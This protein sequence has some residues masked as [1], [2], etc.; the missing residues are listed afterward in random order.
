MIMKRGNYAQHAAI[1]GLGG[2]DRSGEIK[3]YAILTK[4]YGNKALSLMCA[5]GEIAYGMTKNGLRVTAVDIEPEMIAAA[6]KDDPVNTNPCFLTG[7]VTALHLPDKDYDFAFIG[8]GDFHHLLSEK[9]MLEAL[10]C[11]HRH[12]TDKG[13][14]AFELIYPGSESRQS[15]KRRFDPPNQSETSLK[16]WKLGESSYNAATMREY[17]KQEVFIEEQGRIESFSHEFELQLI[18]RETLAGL[19]EKAGFEITAEYGGY[20]FE[21]WHPGADKWL[22]EC[23]KIKPD[24]NDNQ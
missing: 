22:V 8:T 15:P 24:V 16:T 12:L 20:D 18:S 1:W 13:C 21:A 9:E 3:F 6:K 10:I 5:T 7:D 4:K 19:L 2:P 14:L 23:V 17:I 11:I